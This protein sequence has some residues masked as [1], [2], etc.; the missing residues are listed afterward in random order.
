MKYCTIEGCLGKHEAKGYCQKH[1]K[2]HKQ[3]GDPLAVYKYKK[4]S[5]KCS[6]E[7]CNEPFYAL[8][9][10]QK[11]YERNMRYGNPVFTKFEMHGKSHVSE[12]HI[13]LGMIQRCY[14]KNGTGYYRYGARGIKVCNKWRESFIAFI[15][16]MGMKPFDKAQI[17]RKDNDKDYCPENCRWTTCIENVRN[18]SSTK[19]T[20]QIVFS[21]RSKSY[22]S[23]N[24]KKEIASIYNISIA[25]IYD[26]LSYRTWKNV[27]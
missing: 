17:D 23:W 13:W 19:L 5:L 11:H 3:Y 20:T 18:S 14:N 4:Y 22:N 6:V 25:T 8:G 15:D 9:Y 21:I 10:C 27:V 24:E 1:Y 2:K 7:L 26:I 12:Y 16:D